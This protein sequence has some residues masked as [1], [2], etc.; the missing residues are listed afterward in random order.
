MLKNFCGGI[1]CDFPISPAKK[2]PAEN[3]AGSKYVDSSLV[4]HE[5]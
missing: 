1:Y 4:A 3:S 2:D 5:E